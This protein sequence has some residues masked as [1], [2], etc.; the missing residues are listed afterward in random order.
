MPSFEFLN[1]DDAWT[2]SGR[3]QFCDPDVVADS[4]HLVEE[5]VEMHLRHLP[6]DRQE[7]GEPDVDLLACRRVEYP[8]T[9]LISHQ[10]GKTCRVTV[11]LAV[12]VGFLVLPDRVK[13]VHWEAHFE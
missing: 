10:L 2:P 1:R 9:G 3:S 6:D 5:E 7:L 11:V 8:L 13:H 12:P 4:D